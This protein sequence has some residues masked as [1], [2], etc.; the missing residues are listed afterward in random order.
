MNFPDFARSFPTRFEASSLLNTNPGG[1]KHRF[2]L[3]GRLTG[4]N[5]EQNDSSCGQ[6]E[7]VETWVR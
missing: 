7:K 5:S 3:G 6:T 1:N 2:F 4:S